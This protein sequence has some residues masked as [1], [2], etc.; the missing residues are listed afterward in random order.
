MTAKIIVLATPNPEKTAGAKSYSEQ[1]Q[2]LLQAAGVKPTFRGPVAE[3]IAGD[4]PPS[5]IMLLEFPNAAAASAFFSQDAYQ[6]LV[7][8]RDESFTRMEIY[9]VG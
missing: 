8:L 3:A 9:L 4:T 1:V 6:A 5:T 2:P 7:P